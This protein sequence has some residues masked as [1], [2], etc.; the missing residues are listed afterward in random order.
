M[1]AMGAMQKSKSASPDGSIS[2]VTPAVDKHMPPAEPLPQPPVVNSSTDN[3]N[4]SNDTSSTQ[5]HAPGSRQSSSQESGS[6]TPQLQKS[7]LIYDIARTK[8]LTQRTLYRLSTE[9]GVIKLRSRPAAKTAG[10]SSG[11]SAITGNVSEAAPAMGGEADTSAE[12][13]AYSAPKAVIGWKDQGAIDSGK[14]APP[15]AQPSIYDTLAVYVQM[16]D[17]SGMW[18]NCAGVFGLMFLTYVLTALNFGI[19]GFAIAATYGAQWYRNSITRY[20]RAVKDDLRRAYERSTITRTLESVGWL[21]EFVTRFWLMFEPSLSRM[22]IDIVDPILA[23]STPGFLD[24]LRLSTFTLGTKA[25]RIDGVRTYSELEDRNQIVMDWHA[26]FTPNDLSDVPAVLR[27]NRVNP[28]V[29]LTVR[30]G[31]GFIGAG[32]PILV[33]NMVFKG[34]M[35][36]KLQLGPVFPH[37]RTAE[38]CFLER[39]TIDFTLKPV[40]GDT[41]GFDIAHIPG[42][43]TFILD[44]MH[45]TIG[46][47]FYAP[48]RFTI[49]VEQLISG[50]VANIPSAKGVLIVHVQGAR[51]LPKMDTFGKADPYVMISTIKHPEVTDRTQTIEKTLSPSW[52]QKLFLLIYSKTDTVQLE[53]YDW[54][55]VGKDD[56]IGFVSYPMQKLL[57]EPEVEGVTMP[58]KMGETNR[59]NLTFDMSYFPVSVRTTHAAAVDAEGNPLDPSVEAANAGMEDQE[60]VEGDE[61]SYENDIDSNTG[62]LRLFVRSASGLAATPSLARKLCVRA[63][64]RI[65]A[66]LAINCPEVKNT[67]APSWEIG[68]ETFVADKDRAIIHLR[69][70]NTSNDRVIGTLKIKL[71]DA[72]AHQ[73]GESGSDWY[74]LEGSVK[75]QVRVNVKW[76]PILMDADVA[77]SLGQGKKLPGPPIG[78]VK[79]TCHEGRHLRNVEAASGRKSDPYMSVM[80]QNEMRG[81]T[82]YIANTLDP[83][84]NET[85]FIPVHRVNDTLAL[86]CF[87]WNR[88]ERDKPLGDALLKVNRLIGKKS[89]DEHGDIVYV[90]TEPLEMWAGLRQRNGKIKGEIRFRAAFVPAIN[91]DEMLSE[92]DK[93]RGMLDMSINDGGL[94]LGEEEPETDIASSSSSSSSSSDEGEGAGKARARP[95][96]NGRGNK[97][98]H[99]ATAQ[100]AGGVGV[101]AG[102]SNLPRESPPHMDSI[103]SGLSGP[104][105]D[106]L[107]QTLARYPRLPNIDYTRFKAG[108]ISIATIGC[109]GLV[110]PFAGVFV[111]VYM[112]GNKQ[113][114]VMETHPSRRRG[115][116]HMWEDEF[117]QAAV[118]EAELDTLVFDVRC[119]P[120]GVDIDSD[121]MISIGKVEYS[122]MELLR[123]K[124]VNTPEPVW[125][126][127]DAETGEVL[128]LVRYDPVEDPQLLVTESIADQGMVRM[129]IASATN[130]PAADKSG[131]SDPY[132]VALVDGVKVWESETLKKTLNPRWNEQ[133]ELGIRQRSKTVLTLEVY[134]WNQIQSHTLLGTATIPLK[135]LPIGEAVEHDYPLASSNGKA[136]LQLKFLFKPGYVEQHDDSSPVLLNV[137]HTVVKAPVTVIK[138]GASIVGNVVGGIFGKISGKK[139][140]R[141]GGRRRGNSGSSDELA[142]SEDRKLSAAALQALPQATN[143]PRDDGGDAE[144]PRAQLTGASQPQ[145][146][147]EGT[148]SRGASTIPVPRLSDAADVFPAPG[149]VHFS[150]ESAEARD[151]GSHIGRQR[152]LLVA[153]EMNHKT[154]HKTR[155]EKDTTAATWDAEHF[156]LP[157]LQGGAPVVTV[158]L[159]DHSSFRGDKVLAEFAVSI[160]EE[161]KPELVANSGARASAS[162]RLEAEAGSVV[163]RMEFVSREIAIDDPID[164][165]SI[166]GSTRGR[167]SERHGRR[168]SAFSRKSLK[169]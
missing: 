16:V 33:E 101:A 115:R 62:L 126:Q 55:N 46:P 80:V 32:M 141:L 54:N 30:V 103:F 43:R 169:Q 94:V 70:I 90:K 79:L 87:D 154:L 139:S 11:A 13:T 152:N 52:N 24:S 20:R 127:L 158:A 38:V 97:M 66:D 35:Q 78:F 75:G 56:K 121:E 18:R 19:F 28:K 50:A 95:T 130:L 132:V 8:M 26:S 40:G 114:P 100:G 44:M 12:S 68:K 9:T 116:E 108:V 71:E 42:L 91:F 25:P 21:N 49:D 160:F 122:V 167:H 106:T 10:G 165:E 128:V 140:H 156:A 77:N 133:A 112:N 37:V 135:D 150:I 124:M 67:D 109:R 161:L 73:S 107:S 61:A 31:R 138:G 27:E 143:M 168:G 89:K 17:Q 88:V 105:G 76:R 134:D 23:Q 6:R 82:R 47:M 136:E 85:L 98:A 2:G 164:S 104:G 1:A 7:K 41:F 129:R 131:T 125:L 39:P 93:A 84:W 5:L 59:G 15:A 137:A 53:V 142:G 145:S 153:V 159:K 118:P 81:K 4:A 113:A 3:N 69:L 60:Q 146:P 96:T 57:E 151:G 99:G 157:V 166:S 14:K 83:V 48:N 63:E 92:A 22:V 155:V 119:R 74:S 148:R 110:R 117:S 163:M 45:S 58:I 29:V 111:T 123:R 51:G 86:E 34:K 147:N 149:M 120:P 65:N 144:A 102:G 64:A 36:V 72:L 162:A